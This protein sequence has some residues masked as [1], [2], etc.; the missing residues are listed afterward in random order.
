MF[1]MNYPG[2]FID[3]HGK[4]EKAT[5]KITAKRNAKGVA[6]GATIKH[7]KNANEPSSY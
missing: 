4:S 7:V 1:Y 2:N 5:A 3:L 6:T